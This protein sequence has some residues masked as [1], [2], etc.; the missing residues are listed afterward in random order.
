MR[1]SIILGLLKLLAIFVNWLERARLKA[2]GKAEAYAEAK[3]VQDE[4]VAKANAARA[5]TDAASG[6]PDPFDRDN[7]GRH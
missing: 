1:L 2:E 4:R 6:V 7:A 3:K 5:D